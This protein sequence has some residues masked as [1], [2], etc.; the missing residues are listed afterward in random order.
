MIDNLDDAIQHC[1]HKAKENRAQAENYARGEDYEQIK[2]QEC[3]ECAK[4]HEQLA[5]WLTELVDRREADRWIPVS[6]RLPDKFEDVIVR[7][8]EVTRTY[9]GYYIGNGCWACDRGI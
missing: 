9:S 1:L 4:D 6:E 7:D 3:E 5:S 2:G 8:I